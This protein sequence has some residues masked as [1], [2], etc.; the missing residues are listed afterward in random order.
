MQSA[1]DISTYVIYQHCKKGSPITNLKLQKILY[2]VQGYVSKFCNEPA[3]PEPIYNWPYG[4]VVP[5]A[6]YAYNEN[7]AM[8]IPEPDSQ[9]IMQAE[10]RLGRDK[11]TQ[12]VMDQVINATCRYAA[13][14]LVG[15]THNEDPW[16]GTSESQEITYP[17]IAQ[18]FRSHDPLNLEV[19]R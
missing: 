16:K 11:T 3:F 15:M 6:Y 19:Q 2:Y 12:S 17:Q 13:S 5:E 1:L 8:P 18:Y 10:F 14:A 4:P 7:R 9:A